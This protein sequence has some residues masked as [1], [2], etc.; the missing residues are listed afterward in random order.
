MNPYIEE[1]NS[2][3]DNYSI[4]SKTLKLKIEGFL[5]KFR[6][7]CFAVIPH[8]NKFVIFDEDDNRY[9]ENSVLNEMQFITLVSIYETLSNEVNVKTDYIAGTCKQHI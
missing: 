9:R 7:G 6:G 3:Y 8:E 5:P 1:K 2:T 4:T